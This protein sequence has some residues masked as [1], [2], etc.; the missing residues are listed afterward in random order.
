MDNKTEERRNDYTKLFPLLSGKDE[1]F[2]MLIRYLPHPVQIFAPD[3]TSV[4]INN[5]MLE[6]T[7]TR[8]FDCHVGKYNVFRDPILRELGLAEKIRPVL[9]GKTIFLPDFNV[10][11]RDMIRYYD[12]EERDVETISADVTCFPLSHENY[13]ENHFAAVFIVKKIYPGKTEIREAKQYIETHWLEPFDVEKTAKAVYL[14]KSYFTKYFK[15]HT[16]VTPHEY[17]INYKIYKLKEKLLDNNLLVSEAFAACN[18]VYNGHF[19]GLFKEKVGLSPTA[20]RRL[21]GVK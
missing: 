2:A 10:S 11:Y 19:A 6:V 13:V 3:G 21:S 4:L 14:S 8:N 15:K 17:Y 7:G 20:Y 16:G 9:A 12:V 1:L 5:A 18:I